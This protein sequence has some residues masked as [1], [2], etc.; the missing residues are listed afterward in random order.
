[1]H[2]HYF[3]LLL[4]TFVGYCG[5]SPAQLSQRILTKHHSQKRVTQGCYRPANPAST[6]RC[7]SVADTRH[8]SGY[9][10][11]PRARPAHT[12]RIRRPSPT[13]R[14]AKRAAW[15][16][17]TFAAQPIVVV[18]GTCPLEN[19]VQYTEFIPLVRE[20]DVAR[21]F[22]PPCRPVVLRPRVRTERG[23]G[24]KRQQDYDDRF[25]SRVGIR[26]PRRHTVLACGVRLR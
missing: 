13:L 16:R 20:L 14:V 3:F 22:W 18:D 12:W 1:L 11:R 4:L 8:H 5:L 26:A 2:G 17:P 24:H 9:G 7:N 10:R 23:V 19:G 6:P 15:P 25:A 21:L